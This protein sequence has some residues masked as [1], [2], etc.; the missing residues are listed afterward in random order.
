M[1]HLVELALVHYAEKTYVENEFK[2]F[3][4]ADANLDGEGNMEEKMEPY[5]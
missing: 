1:K 2:I 5:E 3:R 4:V